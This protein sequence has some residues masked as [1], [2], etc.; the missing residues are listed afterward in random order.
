MLS[1]VFNNKIT[2]CLLKNKPE[3]SNLYSSVWQLYVYPKLLRNVKSRTGYSLKHFSWNHWW[4]FNQSSA[5]IFLRTFSYSKLRANETMLKIHTPSPH[6]H[7]S[8]PNMTEY[9]RVPLCHEF[10][11]VGWTILCLRELS[12]YDEIFL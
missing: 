5:L 11:I 2:H 4:H 8:F 9:G 6:D 1:K 7:I 10:F 12:H 3:I